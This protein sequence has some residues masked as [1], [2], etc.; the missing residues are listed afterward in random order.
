MDQG[1]E[2]GCLLRDGCCGWRPPDSGAASNWRRVLLKPP[3]TTLLSLWLKVFWDFGSLHQRRRGDFSFVSRHK[4][5]EHHIAMFLH[6][7][8]LRRHVLRLVAA[9]VSLSAV[10]IFS[11]LAG[12]I[13]EEAL[14]SGFSNL[15]THFQ[16]GTT[17]FVLQLQLPL[18]LHDTLHCPLAS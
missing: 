12:E 6:L 7:Q 1:K 13:A 18:F 4:P 5:A 2:S 10:H 3:A 17:T 8:T 15:E 11:I 9:G 16:G 14:P